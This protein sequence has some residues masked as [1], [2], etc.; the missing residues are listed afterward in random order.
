MV[1]SATPFTSASLLA[2]P[3]AVFVIRHGLHDSTA[4]FFPGRRTIMNQV[5]VLLSDELLKT[6]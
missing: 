3:F 5:D 1:C 2:S 6:R 4:N